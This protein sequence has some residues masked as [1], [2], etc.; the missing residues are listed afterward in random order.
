[1]PVLQSLGLVTL[2]WLHG[3]V[4]EAMA[5]SSDFVTAVTP[6][7]SLPFNVCKGSKYA[8]SIGSIRGCRFACKAIACRY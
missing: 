3:L 7:E 8:L 2:F 4:L 6:V 5:F 1:M